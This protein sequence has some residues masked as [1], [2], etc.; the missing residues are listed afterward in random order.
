VVQEAGSAAMLRQARIVGVC[1]LLVIAGGLVAEGF[2]RGALVVPGDAA[3]TTAAIAAD[4]GRWRLGLTVHLLYLPAG[5][6]VNVLLYGLLKPVQVTLARLA[7]AFAVTSVAIEAVSLVQ[8]QVPLL[9][10]AEEE[11]ALAG[12]GEGNRQGLAYLAVQQFAVGFAVALVFFAGFCVL[13]GVLLVRSGLVPQVLGVL[14]VVAGACYLVSSLAFLDARE[15]SERLVPW[16]LLPS[17]V[18]ELSLAL[19]LVVRGVR[20]PAPEPAPDATAHTT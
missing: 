7:L 12:L 10:I 4:T 19:W 11:A 6:V 16:I 8:L 20:V 17:L 9:L 14:L 13:A 3:A 5:L 2:V 15:L 18:A 1:Y